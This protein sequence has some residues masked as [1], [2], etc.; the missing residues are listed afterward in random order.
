MFHFLT[1]QPNK[2]GISIRHSIRSDSKNYP[3][4]S[5]SENHYPH[6]PNEDPLDTPFCRANIGIGKFLVT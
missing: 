1:G 5:D 2:C 4:F 3:K 6:S